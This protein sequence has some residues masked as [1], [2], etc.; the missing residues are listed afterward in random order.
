MTLMTYI[1]PFSESKYLQIAYTTWMSGAYQLPTTATIQY[2]ML[3]PVQQEKLRETIDFL[4]FDIENIVFLAQNCGFHESFLNFLQRW[5]PQYE[6]TITPT[7]TT[8]KGNNKAEVYTMVAV[9][10][11]FFEDFFE[12][13]FEDVP[14][15]VKFS[16]PKRLTDATKPAQ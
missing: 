10:E 4:Y 6:L 3:L 5:Q 13:F 7:Q 16:K 15:K 1:Q 9:F 11:G 12:G 8:I 2:T 14:L